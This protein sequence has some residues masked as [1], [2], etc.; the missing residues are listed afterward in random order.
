MRSDLGAVAAGAGLVAVA[1]A[2][3]AVL[4]ARGV[5]VHAAAAPLFAQVRPV[6]GVGSLAAVAVAAGLVLLGPP[7]AARLPWPALLGAAFLATVAWSAALALVRGPA[8]LLHPLATSPEYLAELPRLAG[9]PVHA[10]LREFVASIPADAA[11]PWRTHVAGHP[12]GM[13]L[14]FLLLARSGAGGAGPAAAL[15]LLGW[16][17]GVVAV[18]ATVRRLAGE[19]PA[20]VALPF[21]VLSPAVVWAGVSADAVLAGAGAF[22]LYLLARSGTGSLAWAVPAGLVLGT[23]CYLSYGAPLLGVPALA[24]LLL[25]RR[26]WPAVIAAAAALVVALAF[27][28]A[29]FA[30]WEGYLAV[31]GRYLSGFG[32]QRPYAYWV[33]ADVAALAVAAG[34][35]VLAGL[36]RWPD[37]PRPIR[38][39]V[40][41]SL[42]AVL[43]ADVSGMSK[44]EVERIWLPWTIWL[45]AAAAAL[46]PARAR[47][48]LAAQAV[49]A[50]AVEHLLLTPW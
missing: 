38:S 14:V 6:L 7:A 1:A 45:A 29:G 49:A 33:W 23:C 11:R 42:V 24:V 40:L 20:R 12:P 46:P 43:L 17:G 5:P 27:W 41:G 26:A 18:A 34:P 21:L 30:W 35:A 8:G 44:A 32:G 31:R 48:W 3:G 2:T 47:P 4:S 22:G 36:R 37:A 28:L 39:L 19:R 15:C 13:T 16:A 25:A 9:V 50:L 10:F